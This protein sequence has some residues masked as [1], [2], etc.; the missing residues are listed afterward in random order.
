MPDLR[1]IH[2]EPGEPDLDT[3]YILAVAEHLHPILGDWISYQEAV[4][5][6]HLTHHYTCKFADGFVM[7]D[8]SSIQ[9]IWRVDSAPLAAAFCK[10]PD[11]N[12]QWWRQ[13]VHGTSDDCQD[14][15][16]ELRERIRQHPTVREV[17]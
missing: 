12:Y 3:L 17:G 5:L 15:I 10:N 11:E 13:E 16:A 2:T 8:P 6:A 9:G 1:K 7:N 14:A 4:A